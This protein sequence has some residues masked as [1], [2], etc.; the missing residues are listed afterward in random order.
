MTKQWLSDFVGVLMSRRVTVVFTCSLYIVLTHFNL[1]DAPIE[2]YT[3]MMIVVLCILG[4]YGMGVYFSYKAL[5]SNHDLITEQLTIM[6][7]QLSIMKSQR[8]LI[9]VL[10]QRIEELEKE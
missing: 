5:Q 3:S 1:M 9:F 8:E 6:G 10:K 2:S 7:V 4:I